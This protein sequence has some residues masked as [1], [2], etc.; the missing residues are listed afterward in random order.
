V[1]PFLKWF[2]HRQ[3]LAS[4]IRGGFP[5]NYRRYYEPFLG[6]GSVFLGLEPRTEVEV[7][8]DIN[9]WLMDCYRALK[10]NCEEVISI[11]GSLVP[12]VE[13]YKKLRSIHPDHIELSYLLT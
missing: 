11:L 9:P 4:E 6:G 3:R 8:G 7:L 12:C 1:K 5:A 13:T 10:D 2:G